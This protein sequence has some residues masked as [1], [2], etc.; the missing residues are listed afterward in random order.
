[1]LTLKICTSKETFW[2]PGVREV[3]L[4]G[5]FTVE[6]ETSDSKITDG[7]AFRA[8]Q[9]ADLIDDCT[10]CMCAPFD[11]IN[12][13]QQGNVILIIREPRYDDFSQVWVVPRRSTYLMSDIGTTIDHI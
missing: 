2:V 1:M 10:N 9:D 13:P 6:P 4:L 12:G 11:N 3:T 5:S 8:A 7:L